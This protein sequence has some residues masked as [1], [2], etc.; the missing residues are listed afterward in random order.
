MVEQASG[1]N[2]PIPALFLMFLCE[3]EFKHCHKDLFMNS[4]NRSPLLNS[5]DLLWFLCLSSLQCYATFQTA[6]V[7]GVFIMNISE[8]MNRG[9]MCIAE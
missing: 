7:Q 1:M 6:H 4:S 9:S 8:I 5:P 3:T 2:R